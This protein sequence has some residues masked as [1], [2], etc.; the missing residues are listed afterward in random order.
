MA[1]ALG[2]SRFEVFQPKPSSKLI[3]LAGPNRPE[4]SLYVY[5]KFYLR[6][7]DEEIFGLFPHLR[8]GG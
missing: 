6:W 4:C 1:G 8:L 3:E 5:Y 2:I 7:T